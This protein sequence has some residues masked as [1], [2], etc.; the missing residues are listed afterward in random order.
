MIN[1]ENVYKLLNSVVEGKTLT[2]KELNSYGF[3]A[4]DL[5]DLIEAK[6]LERVRRGY[7]SFISTKDLL[8]YGK[9]LLSLGEI[10]KANQCFNIC[11]E[12]DPTNVEVKASIKENDIVQKDTEEKLESNKQSSVS[13]AS[14]I[15]NVEISKENMPIVKNDIS[16]KKASREDEVNKK[17]IADKSKILAERGV[18]ILNPMPDE[19]YEKLENIIKET[20]NMLSFYIGSGKKKRLVLKYQ[21]TSKEFINYSELYE[22]GSELFHSK[23]YKKSI[24]YFRKLFDYGHPESAI[25]ALLGIAYKCYGKKEMAIDYLTIATELNK[26]SDNYKAKHYDFSDLIA[27]L[28]GEIPEENRKPFFKM[29]AS[30]FKNDL[31]NNYGLQEI[32]NIQRLL[33]SGMEIEDVYDNLGLCD[34]ERTLANLL[35]ARNYY[36]DERY[37]LGDE[38]LK[39]AEQTKDKSDFNKNLMVEVQKNKRFYKNRKN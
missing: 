20:P 11:Y 3:N 12:M 23:K 28:K 37:R 24:P 30:E 29:M 10:D 13:V 26:V 8:D 36:A 6:K 7:Y 39:K 35:L 5:R 21:L 4:K 1:V 27:R 18:I 19:R 2:T 34:E 9:R 15:K 32:E 31:E 17:L 16:L 33:A 25:Y 22:K 14:P 38:Y